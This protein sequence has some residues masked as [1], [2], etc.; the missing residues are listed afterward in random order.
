M[1]ERSA[2]RSASRGGLKLI[3]STSQM[4]RTIALANKTLRFIKESSIKSLYCT[5][6]LA[7]VTQINGFSSVFRFARSVSPLIRSIVSF[8]HQPCLQSNEMDKNMELFT[9]IVEC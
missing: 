8:L 2:E 3:D 1:A 9:A 5:I 6:L 7:H 4:V